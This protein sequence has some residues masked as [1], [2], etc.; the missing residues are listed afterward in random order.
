MNTTIIHRLVG[1]MGQPILLLNNQL[2]GN[3][4][5]PL[6]KSGDKLIGI[7]GFPVISKPDVTTDFKSPYMSV[8]N[9]VVCNGHVPYT[10]NKKGI[11]ISRDGDFVQVL[12]EDTIDTMNVS[13]L[14]DLTIEGL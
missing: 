5:Q 13:H 11:I 12:F 9:T 3:M 1:N 7:M 8:G 10:E 6:V 2:I 4:G 14:Y